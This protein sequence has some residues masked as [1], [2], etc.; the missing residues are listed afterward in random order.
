MNFPASGELQN[1]IMLA[2]ASDSTG[3][4]VHVALKEEDVTL[5]QT[6]KE[7]L[8]YAHCTA[9]EPE[10]YMPFLEYEFE[11]KNW[12]MVIIRFIG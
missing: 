4:E 2:D 5:F 7:L 3:I 9:T 12:Q 1:M 11:Y 8:A 6:N 10:F